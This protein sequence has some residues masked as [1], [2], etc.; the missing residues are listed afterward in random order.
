MAD[1]QA[2]LGY[3]DFLRARYDRSSFWLTAALDTA[4][5]ES[6]VRAKAT[7]YLGSVESDRADYR[8][9]AEL[10]DRA[11]RLS[12]AV[13]ERRHEAY[14]RAMVGRIRLL[15]GDLEGAADELERCIALAE[16]DHW[17]R[18][19]PWPQALL[20]E[21]QV[22][23]GDLTAASRSLEQA[24]AR[25]CQ[26]GDPCWEG[27]SGRGLGLLLEARGDPEGALER[28]ADARSRCGR[29]PDPYVWLDVH[30]LDAQCRIG[31]DV[32][33]PAAATWVATMKEISARTGMREMIARSLLHGARLGVE[34]DRELGTQ[35]AAGIENP[36][37]ARELD[38]RYVR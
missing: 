17:R 18:F 6:A 26:I 11:V 28:L 36:R 9:A 5:D 25:A 27:I 22:V 23:R 24:F 35:V 14:A 2:E 20:G 29:L 15:T 30:I 1:A 4:G 3:V 16:S 8:A 21:V 32:G 38:G 19:L 33:H 10:L 12:A 34:G 7:G 13:D 37:L 31:I